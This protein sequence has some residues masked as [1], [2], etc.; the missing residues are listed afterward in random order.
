MQKKVA[1]ALSSLATIMQTPCLAQEQQAQEPAASSAI[2]GEI[3]VTAQKRSESIQRVPATITALNTEALET[4]NIENAASLQSVVPGLVV[5]ETFGTSLISLRGISTGV[6]SG[7]EDPSVAT[8]INGVYQP[9]S[10][11]ISSALS[12][13]ERVEVL[14]GPQGTLYGRNATAGVINYVLIRPQDS[15]GG[16][17][18]ASAG[19]FETFGLKGRL[20]GP[21]SDNVRVLV[22][23]VADDQGKGYTKNL[24][25]GAPQSR[26]Q[27]TRNIGGRAALD[28]DLPNDV[29]VQLDAIYQD[30]NS[31]P[32][33]LAFSPSQEGFI[34]AVLSPQSFKPYETYSAF[35]ARNHTR[36]LQLIGT[37][38]APLSDTVTVKSITGYQRFRNHLRID[39]DAST[40]QIVESDARFR[41]NT[42]SQELNLTGSFFN[43]K[44]QSIV[45]LF[46]YDDKFDH[47]GDSPFNLPFFGQSFIFTVDG[48][49]DGKSYSVFTDHTYSVTD[50]LRVQGGLRY[51][52]DKKSAATNIVYSGVD[53]CPAPPASKSW[54]SWTP[55][56]GAQYDV[57]STAM[58]YGQ[59]TKGFKAGGFA[60]SSCMDEFDPEKISGVEIGLKSRLFDNRVRFNI[61]GYKYKISDLQVQKVVDA[62]T[63]LID[64]AAKAEVYGV[65]ASL[66][67]QITD[68][69]R[70]DVA[71]VVQS[72]K[73]DQFLNCDEHLFIGACG[74]GDP[75]IGDAR[76][77][78]ASGNRL[79]RAP[80][81]T[82][83]MGLE[84]DVHLAGGGKILLRGENFLSGR[85]DYSEFPDRDSRQGAYSLQNA[86]VS[87]NDASNTWVVRAFVK[88][89]GDKAIKSGYLFF[90]A[91]RQATGQYAAP[92]TFGAE[93]T[94]RF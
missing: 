82:V 18:T 83:N 92:R 51:N 17:V 55:R 5:G 88:N 52:H 73:Y 32:A 8:H 75:R 45:G 85:V 15:F 22:S 58:L 42:F 41:S 60:A 37:V 26:L 94:K 69:L 54:D 79:N 49:I 61:A 4:R 7:A 46:Y 11:T 28:F 50:R 91:I 77:S 59:Y 81:Y 64:N 35:G 67:G 27:K 48:P 84:Y 72:A 78:D 57:T 90:S 16:E 39:G 36:Y 13:L 40:T 29:S 74:A 80:P 47:H 38:T 43:D 89:I 31:T 87:F 10:R 14:S 71:G 21:L 23:G 70:F 65:E 1:M 25:E 34:Q 30:S 66:T 24:A 68:D 62:G 3:I 19:N 33:A 6:T 93:I 12:D 44:L 86:F 20:S 56:F 53:V 9:R 63:L 2:P 76:L